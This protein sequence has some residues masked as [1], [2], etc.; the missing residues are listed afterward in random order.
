[1][2]DLREAFRKAVSQNPNSPAAEEITSSYRQIKREKA[3]EGQK[4]KIE[5]LG[6]KFYSLGRE[7]LNL[8]TNPFSTPITI[9]TIRTRWQDLQTQLSH[10]KSQEQSQMLC[11]LANGIL[12]SEGPLTGVHKY[13]AISLMLSTRNLLEE[14]QA[15]FRGASFTPCSQVFFEVLGDIA[16]FSEEQKTSFKDFMYKKSGLNGLV[17]LPE[18]FPVVAQWFALNTTP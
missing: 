14:M 17:E 1:M 10:L 7:W 16:G 13:L 2:P 12:L 8:R 4:R 18:V 3:E 9:D 6:L 11:E 5:R 15:L